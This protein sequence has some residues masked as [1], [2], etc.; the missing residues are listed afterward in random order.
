MKSEKQYRVTI[1]K[2]LE[3]CKDRNFKGGHTWMNDFL[4]S[5]AIEG[6][7]LLPIRDKWETPPLLH[8]IMVPDAPWE[9]GKDGIPFRAWPESWIVDYDW[10]EY[11]KANNKEVVFPFIHKLSLPRK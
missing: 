2:L 9:I 10:K 6:L 4:L 5:L 8:Y 1:T 3:Q 7:V 11:I